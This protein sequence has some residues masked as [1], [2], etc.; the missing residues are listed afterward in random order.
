MNRTSTIIPY[1]NL[2]WHTFEFSIE[3]REPAFFDKFLGSVLRGALGYSLRQ[4]CDIGTYRYIFETPQTRELSDRKYSEVPRPYV[5]SVPDHGQTW[6]AT[7]EIF[8]FY[9]TL[10]GK[11]ISYLPHFIAAFSYTGDRG[12]G[13]KRSKFELTS[14][15]SVSIS[16]ERELIYNGDGRFLSEEFFRISL[17]DL[18]SLRSQPTQMLLT[19]LTPLRLIDMKR[20]VR[21]DNFSLQVYLHRSIER[22]RALGYFHDDIP[23][24]DLD[25]SL[26]TRS[27]SIRSEAFLSWQDWE[28][29]V[30]GRPQKMGGV[31]GQVILQGN[32][33][34]YCAILE[35]GQ[36]LHV[37]KGTSYG[38]GSVSV[39]YK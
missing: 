18:Q 38:F 8:N 24:F 28:F 15:E 20:L 10:I 19:F 30:R 37:G 13:L 21:P 33:A 36:W 6:F 29:F 11:G 14:I 31:V 25:E 12:I 23:W 35:S 34:P 39:Q 17:D 7:G 5:I 1:T 9:L 22:I 16:G 4:I 26:I 32:L 3:F 27:E 2:H